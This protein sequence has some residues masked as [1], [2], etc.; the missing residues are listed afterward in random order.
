MAKPPFFKRKWNQI[1]KRSWVEVIIAMI[2]INFL[3]NNI[4]TQNGCENDRV[5]TICHFYLKAAP[6]KVSDIV[7]SEF[8]IGKS[9]SFSAGKKGGKGW[10]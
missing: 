2:I 9:F 8:L 7:I 4:I 6:P 3:Y 5:A 1:V 10:G